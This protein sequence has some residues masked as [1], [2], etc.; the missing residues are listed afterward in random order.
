M[1]RLTNNVG[2]FEGL[3]FPAFPAIVAFASFLIF[4]SCCYLGT[5]WVSVSDILAEPLL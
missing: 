5:I 3:K 2:L 1:T 4:C